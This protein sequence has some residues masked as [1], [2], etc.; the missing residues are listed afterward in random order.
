VREA[1]Q[2]SD[3]DIP[4]ALGH[5]EH[6]LVRLTTQARLIDPITRHFFVEAGIAP[7]M[8][9]LD[10]G[11]GVGD[12]AILLAGLVGPSGEV[13][14]T[15]TSAT[16]LALARARI[17]EMRLG[18]VSFQDG[19]P[20]ELTFPVPFDAVAG[21]YILQFMPDPS[22]ALNKIVQNV[23]PGGV[24]VF[25]EL[26]WSGA[27]SVPPAPLYDRCCALCA[28]TIGKLGAD[29]GMGPKLHGVFER[30]GLHPPVMR[31]EAVIGSGFLDADKLDLVA[32][33]VRTLLPD[34]ER[35]GIV[36]RDEIDIETL[37]SH[38]LDEVASRGSVVI[39][40]AEVGAWSRT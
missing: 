39:G 3:A 20:G 27:R 33:L 30:A 14:G 18:N 38:M 19:D 16:A 40:R 13:V 29:T 37:S 17:D 9:V 24:V 15:D 1:N 2:S 28:E 6:E 36:K 23:R 31:L 10:V 35:L 22:A 32:D 7:G 8:R 34:M 11:S 4:Y 12:V 5:A 25:H 21:R 26:D